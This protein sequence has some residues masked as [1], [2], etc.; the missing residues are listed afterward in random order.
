AEAAARRSDPDPRRATEMRPKSR[1]ASQSRRKDCT[2]RA[3]TTGK[4]N[5][6][7]ARV[8]FDSELRFGRT[9]RFPLVA[10]HL[11]AANPLR[12]AHPRRRKIERTL[13]AGKRV[14]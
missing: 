6:R 7:S 5:R 11:F 13:S 9:Y 1:T 3:H 8:G 14:G 10:H 12:K 4:R 2:W